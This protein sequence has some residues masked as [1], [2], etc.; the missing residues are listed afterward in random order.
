MLVRVSVPYKVVVEV[1]VEVDDDL[2]EGAAWEEARGAAES[3]VGLRFDRSSM[4]VTLHRASDAS[5]VECEVDWG[6]AEFGVQE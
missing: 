4:G 5:I 6:M 2:D 1:D 3:E